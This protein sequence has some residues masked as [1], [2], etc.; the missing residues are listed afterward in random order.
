MTMAGRTLHHHGGF[1]FSISP[2]RG[3]RAPELD[4]FEVLEW[5]G[6]FLARLHDV[7][8]ARPFSK[9]PSIGLESFAREPRD[10]LLAH[11]AVAP[12]V[13]GEWYAAVEKAIFLIAKHDP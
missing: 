12:E 4:D 8:A 13:R 6:R 9:R 11:D 1:D 5:I 10:W 2:W 3:G 7:G